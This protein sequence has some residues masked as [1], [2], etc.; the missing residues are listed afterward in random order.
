MSGLP[1]MRFFLITD[2]LGGAVAALGALWRGPVNLVQHRVVDV[3]AER[4]LDGFKVSA[5]D[6][7]R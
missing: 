3:S 4:A 2:A 7:L 1:V 6:R 5:C